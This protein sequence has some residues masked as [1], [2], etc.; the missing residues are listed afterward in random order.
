MPSESKGGEEK[1]RKMGADGLIGEVRK[2]LMGAEFVREFETFA[3]KHIEPF[4]DALVKGESPASD[5]G[6]HSHSF[7]DTYKVYLDHFERR[8]EQHIVAAGATVGDFMAV[9]RRRSS[10]SDFDPN[11]FFLGRLATTEYETFIVLMMN[12]AKRI[13]KQRNDEAE[14]GRPQARAA[15]RR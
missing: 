11:R 14:S 7:Y 6:D 13:R 10:M 3:E 5:G 1:E 12:E 2:V 8:V 4:L 15:R 9:A